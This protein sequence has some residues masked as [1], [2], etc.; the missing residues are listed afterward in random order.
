MMKCLF[1]LVAGAVLSAGAAAAQPACSAKTCSQAYRSCTTIHCAYM[2]GHN[3][4]AHCRPE[5]ERCL[6]TGEFRGR[7]C[8]DKGLKRR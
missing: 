5:Y 4:E 8:W 6:Q 2:R 7:V 3:C 1:V